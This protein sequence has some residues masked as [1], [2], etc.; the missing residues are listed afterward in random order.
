MAE[1]IKNLTIN[2]VLGLLKKP[3]IAIGFGNVSKDNSYDIDTL[4]KLDNFLENSYDPEVQVALIHHSLTDT[5]LSLLMNQSY[6]NDLDDCADNAFILIYNLGVQNLIIWIELSGFMIGY[7]MIL[8]NKVLNCFTSVP[9]F[10]PTKEL[11]NDSSS[12]IRYYLKEQ[13]A[14]IKILRDLSIEEMENEYELCK[15]K[16][17]S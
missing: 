7:D 2:N 4:E 10:K 13:P 1:M 15:S 5:I 16:S 11:L 14:I 8:Q 9:R 17:T 3:D 6:I 12:M